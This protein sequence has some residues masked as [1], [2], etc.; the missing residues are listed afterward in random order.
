ME[1]KDFRIVFMGTPEFAVASLEALVNEGYT[2][3]GV[4]T[5][6]DK[7]AGRGKKLQSSAVKLYAESKGLTILQPEKLKAPIFI[8]ALQALKADLQVVVAF[9]MLP[10]IVWNM[11]PKGTINLHAS[12]LPQYRGAAPINR[13]IMNGEKVTGLSTFFLTHEIDTGSIIDRVELPI[14]EN[15]NAGELHDRM[16]LAGAD[17]LTTTIERIITGNYTAISQDSASAG[18]QTLKPAPKIFKEDCIIEWNNEG[19]FIF[20]QIRGL[21]PYPGAF[22]FIHSENTEPYQLKIFKSH[23]EPYEDLNSAYKPGSVVIE[24][25]NKMKI[26]SINGWIIATEV[27]QS[28][29]KRMSVADY[30]RGLHDFNGLSAK[31]Q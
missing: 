28:G 29:R 11:P 16:M 7:P 8:E 3:A 5:A 1:K 21:S 22:T 25:R 31:N 12:L 10:E 30:L 13:A 6:P 17:L 14:G 9:R 19:A 2:I 23:F 20:N 18:L 15:E 27:Q 26:A 24:E 4:I